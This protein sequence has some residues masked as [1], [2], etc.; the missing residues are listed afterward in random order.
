[1]VRM[2]CVLC[3]I[4]VI[5]GSVWCGLKEVERKDYKPFWLAVSLTAF[6]VGVVALLC[7]SVGVA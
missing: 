1:M 7:W 3:S 6:V 4:L 2:A 5:F